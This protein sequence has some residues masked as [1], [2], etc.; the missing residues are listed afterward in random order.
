MILFLGVLFGIML[1][2]M[3]NWISD[4]TKLHEGVSL[5][6]VVTVFLLLLAVGGLIFFVQI[7][8]EINR[9]ADQLDRSASRLSD[10]VDRYPAAQAVLDSVPLLS[11]AV[12]FSDATDA[13]DV[14]DQG[15][16]DQSATGEA[17]TPDGTTQANDES[18]QGSESSTNGDGDN[19][20]GAARDQ[21]SSGESTDEQ[22][23]DANKPSGQKSGGG[24]KKQTEADKSGN[25]ISMAAMQQPL[26]KLTSAISRLFQTTF[27]VVVNCL[28]IFFVGLFLA[29][30]PQKYVTGTVYLFPGPYRPRVEQ[31]MAELGHTLWRWLLGR[32][33]TMAITGFGAFLV[34]FLVG[35]P[36]AT[37][38]GIIT[39]ILCFIPNIGAAIALMLA[40][41]AALPQGLTQV[42]TVFVG[43]VALQM[44]ESYVITPLI[45][46]RQVALPPA[47]LLAFQAFLGALLG[48]IGAAI[49]S[50]LLAALMVIT[51]MLYVGDYLGDDPA[52]AAEA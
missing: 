46:Q 26:Q 15:D 31:V 27:G 23:G 44:V 21:A 1:T 4:K 38:I 25:S 11:S 6:I 51:K 12:D 8:S 20:D 39:A 5:G 24:S 49:A 32:F 50:P 18:R 9:I 10:L 40:M 29:S 17:N 48:F 33:A 30:A 35:V 3:R 42:A 41:L 7:N 36:M 2:T 43:Y 22:N 14:N 19:K 13:P 34:M 52:A 28:L 37:T 45:Q 16:A 47:M